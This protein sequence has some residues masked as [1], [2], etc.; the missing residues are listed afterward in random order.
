MAVKKTLLGANKKP[1]GQALRE[2]ISAV[3][4]PKPKPEPK[5]K[6]NIA[7]VLREKIAGI[8]QP[9]PQPAREP[10]QPLS[11]S[12]R[13][14]LKQLGQ[15]QK[16]ATPAAATPPAESAPAAGNGQTAAPAPG[17][18]GELG[19]SRTKKA[20]GRR[21]KLTTLLSSAGGPAE[22]FGG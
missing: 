20:R 7:T 6:L 17:P 3:G 4:T 21:G 19:L 9:K 2:A 13:E 22:T 14:K 8:G 10:R 11:V 5:P 15:P 18:A 12:V 16:A 1:I